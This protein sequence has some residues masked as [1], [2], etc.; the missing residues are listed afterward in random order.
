[1]LNFHEKIIVTEKWMKLGQTVGIFMQTYLS[2]GCSRAAVAMTQNRRHLLHHSSKTFGKTPDTF[3]HLVG[4]ILLS[5]RS[6]YIHRYPRR[7]AKRVWTET[8]VQS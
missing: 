7:E 5:R 3:A 1:M 4:T 2:S 6:R 8:R